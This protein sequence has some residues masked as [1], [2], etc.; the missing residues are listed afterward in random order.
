MRENRIRLRSV[1]D[2][3]IRSGYI[4]YSR[5]LYWAAAKEETL[6][7]VEVFMTQRA[8]LRCCVHAGSSLDHE[9]GGW[10]VGQLRSDHKSRKRYM[11]VEGA[12]PAP[13]TE[14]GSAFLTFTQDSQVALHA[15]MEARYPGAVLLGWYHTH[16]RM[17][18]FFSDYD[19]WLHSHFF[20]ET[21]Q[22]ALVIEPVSRAGG[23]FIRQHDGTLDQRAYFGFYELTNRGRSVVF[24]QNLTRRRL[25]IPVEE[26]MQT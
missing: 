7:T 9:A 25:D 22:V 1:E 8:F 18:I 19:A 6:P 5:S 14:R 20:Q 4:P 24:W 3:G 21:W 10:L 11:V 26:E 23:F 12:L 16:P 2:S 15:E 13:F 17:G